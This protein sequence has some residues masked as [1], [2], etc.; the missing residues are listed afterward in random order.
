MSNPFEV[1]QNEISELKTILSDIQ[2]EIKTPEPQTQTKYL[3]RKD[4]AELLQINISSVFNWTKKGTLK[5]YQ[6]GGKIFYKQ[7]DIDEAM[8]L[9]KN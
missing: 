2:R 5:S 4:V 6:M 1:L 7:S 9:L 8:T 3:T